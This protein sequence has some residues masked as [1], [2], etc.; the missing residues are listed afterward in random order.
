MATHTLK[1]EQ[2][3][4]HGHFSRDR[5]PCLTIESGDTVFFQTLDAGWGLEPYSAD[6][7]PRPFFEPREAGSH[8]LCGPVF[9]A[10]A[11]PR[12]TLEIVVGEVRPGPWGYCYAGG[13]S[14]ALNDRL[15][16][17]SERNTVHR[18][19]LDREAMTGR[20]QYGH[21]IKLRP[22]LGVMGMPE[23]VPGPQSTTP[24]RITGGNIDCK[25]IVTGS[26]LFLPIAVRGGLFS[27][28][29]GHAAQGDGEV[30]GLAIECPIEYAALTFHLHP[31]LTVSAPRAKTPAGWITLGLGDTLDEAMFAAL[32]AMLELMKEHYGL[33]RPEALTLASLVVDLRITQ[34]VNG[35]Q[36]VHALLP[37]DALTV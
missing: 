28:G 17:S 2:T 16:L 34:V 19:Q 27:A 20:N 32:E 10:G 1:P 35:T 29:D 26:S 5:T 4:V 30:S 12:M 25:E 37:L 9:V 22:F 11:E 6:G 3:T 7:S 21:Q 18:W 31:S 36:G 14:S 15:G 13:W 8:A 33:E 24:P 23:D